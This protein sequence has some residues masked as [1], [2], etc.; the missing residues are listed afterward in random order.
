[1]RCILKPR[2][3]C[4][5]EPY[6]Y[7]TILLPLQREA[8][9]A[10]W[11]FLPDAEGEE[12]E[13][14][15]FWGADLESH[16]IEGLAFSWAARH[17][18]LNWGAGGAIQAR[19]SGGSRTG[20]ASACSAADCATP[21]T[22]LSRAAP[23]CACSFPPGPQRRGPGVGA[24]EGRGKGAPWSRGKAERRWYFTWE[25][26]PNPEAQTSSAAPLSP[27][28][29][30]RRCLGTPESSPKSSRDRCTRILPCGAAARCSPG[31]R[32][33]WGTGRWRP[34]WCAGEKWEA[35]RALRAE[36]ARPCGRCR[37]R[38]R[39]LPSPRVSAGVVAQPRPAGRGG[40][41]GLLGGARGNP[42]ARGR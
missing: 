8:F 34:S 36:C 17:C 33:A 42:R 2:H 24:R 11:G 19:N 16:L 13:L 37:P 32:G 40:G 27:A 22:P 1:M 3:P 23:A 4:K 5:G 6:L 12:E 26:D 9:P 14:A 38:C 41:G 29:R 25:S 21:H 31:R 39:L 7:I 35:R 10:C 28:R 18:R 15:G 30:A 20:G